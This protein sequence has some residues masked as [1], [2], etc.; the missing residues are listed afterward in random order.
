MKK[1]LTAVL[2]SGVMLVSALAYNRV[3]GFGL[4]EGRT[5]TAAPENMLNVQVTDSS[6]QPLNGVVMSMKNASGL[7][8]GRFGGN[9]GIYESENFKVNTNGYFNEP[10]S[11]FAQFVQ[12]NNL[13][14]VETRTSIGSGIYSEY[15]AGESMSLCAGQ[16]CFADLITYPAGEQTAFTLGANQMAIY[17]D[18]AWSSVSNKGYYSISGTK[19]YFIKNNMVGKVTSLSRSN[20]SAF[21]IIVA[22]KGEATEHTKC[23]IGGFQPCTQNTEYVLYRMHLQELCPE[24]CNASGFIISDDMIL[25]ARQD[26]NAFGAIS[27]AIVVIESG[28][29][30]SVPIPDA[31]G[32]VEFYVNKNTREFTTHISGMR[33]QGSSWKYFNTDENC[34][35]VQTE[36]VTI[37]AVPFPTAG[38]TISELLA[39]NY[40]IEVLSVPDG[41]ANPGTIPVTVT[42][43][44][45]V[46]TLNIVLE[47]AGAKGDVNANSLIDISDATLVLTHYAQTA[48]GMGG[49]LS[50]AQLKAGD[51]DGDSSITISDATAILRYYAEKAAGL[52]P[53]W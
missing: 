24:N 47:K 8:I 35:A 26:T 25:D 19:K 31:E 11:T 37:Q 16:S 12:P 43:S 45:Q 51:T 27:S 30:L 36:T 5:L 7:E 29:V 22:K 1:K 53:T 48:A 9:T 52:N 34:Q 44:Q 23:K 4:M 17:V 33:E 39:G 42:N 38:I 13:L 40:S 32:Y 3:Y 28:G 15:T 41:Y 10:W 20:S 2:T 14:E 50:E 21:E 46:Q 49:S 18:D 6:Q